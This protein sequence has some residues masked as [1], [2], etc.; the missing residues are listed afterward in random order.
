M[1]ARLRTLLAVTVLLAL[2]AGVSGCYNPF[3]PLISG[4]TSIVEPPPS[5]T[6]PADLVRLFKWC[7]ENRD[8]AKYKELFTDDYRFAFSITDTAGNPYR[9]NPWTREDEIASA[10][11]LFVGGSASEPAASSIT[12]IF[13]GN[14]TARDDFRPGKTAKWHQQIQIANLTL[15]ITKSDGSAVRVTGGALFYMVRGDSAVIPQELIGRG[16]GPDSTRWYF[17]RWEDQTNIGG[18]AA[19]IV[20][21]ANARIAGPAFGFPEAMSWGLVKR[22]WLPR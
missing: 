16:F 8:I 4:Q 12:L 2:G 15:T 17:E 1:P 18:G 3:R 21:A 5:P 9:G 7:W 10:A 11:N 20:P 19:S 22:T 14:L 6:T 13:D